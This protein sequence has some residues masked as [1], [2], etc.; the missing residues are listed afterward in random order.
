MKKI[1]F[2]T[3]M[4]LMLAGCAETAYYPATSDTGGQ[5]ARYQSTALAAEATAGAAHSEAERQSAQSTAAAA[6]V[7]AQAYARQVAATSQAQ[8]TVVTFD[9]EA[10]RQAMM[11]EATR[12]AFEQSIEA[13]QEQRSFEATATAAEWNRQATATRQ[14]M[15]YQATATQQAYEANVTSTSAHVQATAA[16]YQST[17]T[18]AAAIREE[19]LAGARD[20]GIPMA[21]LLLAVGVAV[22]VVWGLRQWANRPVIIERSILGDAQPMAVRIAGGGYNFVDI[23]RQPGAVLKVLPSGQVDAP[24]LRSAASEE[25]VTARDQVI[26]AMT[27]PKLGAGHKATPEALPM[28][29]PPEAP[30][31]GLKSVRVLRSLSQANRA[32]LLPATLTDSLEATWTEEEEE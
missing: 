21:L 12:T 25:R 6:Q 3:V 4:A 24:L 13:T 15:I 8:A 18:R 5:Q 9:I 26:D 17:A 28:A 32:G 20:Y 10:T 29:A 27:R 14:T 30:A 19:R 11:I 2:L 7:T 1:L 16:A 23:D 22:L 31:P